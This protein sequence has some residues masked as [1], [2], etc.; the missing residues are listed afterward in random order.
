MYKI[1]LSIVIPCYNSRK[2][3]DIAINSIIK[4]KKHNLKYEILIIDDGSTDDLYT[5]V[6]YYEMVRYYRKDNGGVSS[7]RNLG[8]KKAHGKYILF[9]DSDDYYHNN[10]FSVL[11]TITNEDFDMI[12]WG[13]IID[14]LDHSIDVRV[15]NKLYGSYKSD[16]FLKKFLSKDV[17]QHVSSLCVKKQFLDDVVFDVKYNY[18]EDI[19]FQINLM[20]KVNNIFYIND[21][22]FTYEMRADSAVNAIYDYKRLQQFSLYEKT[23]KKIK[24]KAMLPLF[25]NFVGM[26]FTYSLIKRLNEKKMSNELIDGYLERLY[27][28]DR[29]EIVR[30]NIKNLTPFI[31]KLIKPLII[32]ILKMKLKI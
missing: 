32:K 14:K 7:A 18:A 6:N 30:Y 3:I 4:Q 27:L 12:S 16:C 13:F 15:A 11:E 19:N 22:L 26:A 23:R 9:L 8:I 1:D 17:Y 24:N 20:L 29:V 10:L 28:Y 21:V 31:F 25:D 2:Y 5:V